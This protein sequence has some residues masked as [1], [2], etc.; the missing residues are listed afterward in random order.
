MLSAFVLCIAD[1][2]PAEKAL[3]RGL[4]ILGRV[5]YNTICAVFRKAITDT[6]PQAIHSLCIVHCELCIE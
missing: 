4:E 1:R 5:W 2:Y 3:P 6:S